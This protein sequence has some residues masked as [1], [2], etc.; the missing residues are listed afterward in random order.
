MLGYFFCL[1]VPTKTKKKPPDKANPNHDEI[2]TR[3]I[4]ETHRYL[5]LRYQTAVDYTDTLSAG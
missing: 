2:T 5:Y 4:V 3:D 1:Q